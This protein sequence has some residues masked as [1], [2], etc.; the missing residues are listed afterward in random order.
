MRLWLLT[1]LVVLVG[2]SAHADT[3][4]CWGLATDRSHPELSCTPLTQALLTSLENATKPEVVRAMGAPGSPDVGP[5]LWF[6]SFYAYGQQGYG[7][8][9]AFTFSPAGH[10]KVINADVDAPHHG[11]GM[12][13]VWNVAVPG[14]SD[15]P[16]SIQRCDNI[17]GKPRPL[18]PDLP[19]YS[20][21]T[22]GWLPGWLRRALFAG[23]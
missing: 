16:G 18:Q 15:F 12:K 19:H 4:E 9:V 7:G 22:L 6:D 3:S 23:G 20:T 21:S 14:C 13:F 17:E 8:A 2:S 5:A 1:T 10:V 11:P